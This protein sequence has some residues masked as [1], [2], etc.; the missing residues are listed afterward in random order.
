MEE[1]SEMLVNVDKLDY[2]QLRAKGSGAKGATVDPEG[3]RPIAGQLKENIIKVKKQGGGNP[4]NDV[5]EGKSE[6]ERDKLVLS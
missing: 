3:T 1:A 4:M 5:F 6:E 2:N